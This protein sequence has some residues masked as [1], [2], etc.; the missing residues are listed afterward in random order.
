MGLSPHFR[1]E[2][3]GNTSHHF[4][5]ANFLFFKKNAKNYP[6][7]IGGLVVTE[8]FA[9]SSFILKRNGGRLKSKRYT[10][11]ARTRESHS[12]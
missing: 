12:S 10:I 1:G 2:V 8:E 7:T 11:L 4:L 5:A 3:M 9:I 6:E